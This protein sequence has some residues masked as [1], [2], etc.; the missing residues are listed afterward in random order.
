[1]RERLTDKYIGF[2]PNSCLLNIYDLMVGLNKIN[3]KSLSKH[4]SKEQ[5]VGACRT[6]LIHLFKMVLEDVAE[7]GC[8]YHFASIRP[9]ILYV[10]TVTG[11]EYKELYKKGKF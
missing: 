6:I 9:A 1:M 2:L 5:F 10:D 8:E 4:A 7:T 11:D 3:A